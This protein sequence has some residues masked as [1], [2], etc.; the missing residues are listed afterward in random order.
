MSLMISLAACERDLADW[1]G[2]SLVVGSG[3][4]VCLC[5]H[6]VD[7]EYCH[8]CLCRIHKSETFI[9]VPIVA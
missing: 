8:V 4:F 6:L 5:T 3:W 7:D 2:I 1:L 9:S